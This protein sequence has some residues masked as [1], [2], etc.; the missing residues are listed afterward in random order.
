MLN[1]YVE[2]AS[3]ERRPLKK[4]VTEFLS[5]YRAI[6]HTSTGITPA[7]LLPGINFFGL[8]CIL[9]GGRQRLTRNWNGVERKWKTNR[10]KSSNILIA[11]QAHENYSSNLVTL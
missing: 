5:V 11:K 10:L 3:L 8:V 1:D 9:R 6:P 2:L 4:A 7:F